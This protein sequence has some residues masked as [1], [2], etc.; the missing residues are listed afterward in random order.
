LEVSPPYR[1]QGCA[2]N[3]LRA[4]AVWARQQGADT[5]ALAVTEANGGARALYASQGMQVVG[6]YHYRQ[7]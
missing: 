6:Q 2:Q 7:K 5:L 4:A 1:R 3:I